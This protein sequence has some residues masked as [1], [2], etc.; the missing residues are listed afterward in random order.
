[1]DA[2]GPSVVP[3]PHRRRWIRILAVA[4]VAV[5]LAYAMAA[6]PA[7]A[8][9]GGLVRILF[10]HVGAAWT[11]YLAFGVTAAASAAYLARRAT[12]FDRLAAASA[13]WGV[14][15][16]TVTL[17]T[18]S[19]WARA[20]QGWWWRWDDARLTLTL[21]LWFLY[22]AYLILRQYAEG[23]R[24]A[25]L[26]AVIA[27]AAVPAIILDHFATVLL[28]AFHPPPVA[29]RVDGPALAPAYVAGLVL[30]VAAF[31]L[32]YAEVLAMR[33]DLES[34]RARRDELSRSPRVTT[35][36][37]PDAPPGD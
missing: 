23:R 17:L 12:R 5:A 24:R 36:R 19:I 31:T 10:G 33:L 6:T 32:V 37:S 2:A 3:L 27:L 18:G 7:E 20:T 14:V 29:A 13:E 8:V 11:A 9:M 25:T 26:S 30:A 15:L 28:P 1:V 34:R 22:A 16:T 21:M 4:F 35:S